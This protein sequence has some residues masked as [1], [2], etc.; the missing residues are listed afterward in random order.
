M[1]GRTQGLG[2]VVILTMLAACGRGEQPGASDAATPP[3]GHSTAINAESQPRIETTVVEVSQ[4]RQA[5]TLAGNV[6]YGEDRYSRIS[7]P[8][9]GRVLEVRARLGDRVKAGNILLVVDSPD[10]AQA[11]SEFIREHS[12]LGFA[13][14]SYQLAND[15]YKTKALPLKDLKQAE[16]DLVKAQAEFRRAK[17][18]LLSLGIT[19]AE[20]TKSVS[21]QHITSRF[22][23][24]SPVAGTVVERAVTP[25]Q[26]V[27]GD[28]GQVLFTVADLEG[29]Q[30]VAD[31]Y[32]RDLAVI[33]QGQGAT[34]TVEAYPGVAFPAVVAAIGDIVDPNTRTIKVRASVNNDNHK[35]K[36]GMFARLHL[37]LGAGQSFLAVPK[38]AVLVVNG[39]EYV[40]VMETEGRYSKRAVKVSTASGDL[41]RVLEGL[42]DGDRIIT[43]GSIFL[44]AQETKG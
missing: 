24:R 1:N 4:S 25:G 36:P 3:Q 12:E 29:L 8:V 18:R 5:I 33:D 16:N 34:V 17:E 42:A 19:A 6:A 13:T 23:L 15:M 7:S 31:M 26:S 39:E 41:V 32:E 43:K 28:S 9:Q 40:Y 14:R 37:D 10:I 21:D 2:L 38:E 20:V 27:G 44:E 30:V 11:Y 35:L 22:E